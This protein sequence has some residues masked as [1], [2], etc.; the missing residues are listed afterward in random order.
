LIN[1]AEKPSESIA[2]GGY[3]RPRLV[4]AFGDRAI[5]VGGVGRDTEA[6]RV[7]YAFSASSRKPPSRVASPKAIGRMPVASGSRL[8]V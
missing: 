4:D 1:L 5:G 8:P 7:R 3:R 2:Q 6:R